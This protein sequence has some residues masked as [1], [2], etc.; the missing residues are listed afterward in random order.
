M[1]IVARDG[2]TRRGSWMLQ[3]CL[4]IPFY[5]DRD[6]FLDASLLPEPFGEIYKNLKDG[7]VRSGECVL[8]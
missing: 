2:G 6:G 1:R 5:V 3:T 7:P 8:S 4:Y